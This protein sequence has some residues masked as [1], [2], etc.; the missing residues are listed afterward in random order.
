VKKEKKRERERD[1]ERER[2]REREPDPMANCYYISPPK[3][4]RINKLKHGQK[5]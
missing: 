4:Q 3:K 2:E 5:L 1:R